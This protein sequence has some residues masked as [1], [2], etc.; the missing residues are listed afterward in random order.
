MIH[1]L[2]SQCCAYNYDI[3]WSFRLFLVLLVRII[4]PKMGW[5]VLAGTLVAGHV[6]VCKESGERTTTVFHPSSFRLRMF[7]GCKNHAGVYFPGEE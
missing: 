6:Y 5:Y 7:I 2:S 3:L 4:L 1:D